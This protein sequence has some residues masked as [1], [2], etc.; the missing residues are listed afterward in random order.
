VADLGSIVPRESIAKTEPEQ[1]VYGT[2][3]ALLRASSRRHTGN[4]FSDDVLA[5]LLSM[6]RVVQLDPDGVNKATLLGLLKS[7]VVADAADADA[8]GLNSSPSVSA[9]LS[10]AVGPT[11]RRCGTL[12]D[13]EASVWPGLQ[14]LPLTFGGSSRIPRRRS[15]VWRISRTLISQRPPARR[16]S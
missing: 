3:L 1:Q 5:A 16:G 7:T 10:I 14:R 9:W 15:R 13:L 8:A 4:E 6:T 12:S 11:A 2:L